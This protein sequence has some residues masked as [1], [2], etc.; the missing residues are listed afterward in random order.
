M[1][2]WAPTKYK[3]M[4]WS[5][6]NDSL[7]RRG[8][9]SIWFASWMAWVPPP[10][11]KRGRRQEFSDA[12]IQT[13]LTLK[14]LFGLPLRQ[15]TGFVESLLQ[16]VG[17]DGAV[18]DFIPLCRP[19]ARQ[20]ICN[21]NPP[22]PPQ[23]VHSSWHTCHSGRR[24]SPSGERGSAVKLRLVQQSLPDRPCADVCRRLRTNKLSRTF[25]RGN[26]D[27]DRTRTCN[28]PLRRGLLY[29]VE[30][31]DRTRPVLAHRA[32]LVTANAHTS[33]ANCLALLAHL[34]ARGIS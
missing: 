32:G 5:A 13:R 9:L 30:P 27:P 22:D 18:P 4:N 1:S 21:A 2:S 17:R 33:C 6:C 29:P 23:Q 14:I 12:A 34:R 26:G 25:W 10:N 28:L 31:R 8:S 24:L 7:K 19:I 15:T 11:G 20:A 3:I 16:P